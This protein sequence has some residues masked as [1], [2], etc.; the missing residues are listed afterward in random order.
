M[1]VGPGVPKGSLDTEQ[2]AVDQARR[3]P[4]FIGLSLLDQGGY[5]FAVR[6]EVGLAGALKSAGESGDADR[7][8]RHMV[9]GRQSH[10]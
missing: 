3:L 8:G 1:H 6:I 5:G 4:P 7:H 9:A 10:F 2:L